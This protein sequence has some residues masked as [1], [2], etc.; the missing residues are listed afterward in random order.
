MQAIMES[1][2]DVAYL[3][4]VITVGIVMIRRAKGDR[5][6]LLFGAMAVVLGSGDA[7]HLVPR[8]YALCTSGLDACTAV[9]GV[10]RMIT[11]VTMTIFYLLLYHVWRLRYGVTEKRSL[12]LSM[13][14]LALARIVLTLLPQNEWTSAH[15]PL[16]WGIY[17][18]IPF[19]IMGGIIIFI[20]RSE[21]KRSGDKAFGHV[22]LAVLL[23]FAFYLPVV[24]WSETIPAIGVL[25]IPKTCA[26]VWLVLIGYAEMRKRQYAK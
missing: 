14:L 11:S 13:Y 7:F 1:V 6:T 23:S 26:Y 17:R 24:L 25:M 15:P 4:L 8:V 10:G 22:W 19:A 2:F 9:L 5:Q 20:F 12:T 16:A 18:N 21:A 3:I